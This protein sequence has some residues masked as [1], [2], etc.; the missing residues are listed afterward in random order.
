MY[1]SFVC[2]YVVPPG[3][4]YYNNLLCYDYFSSL[5]VVSCTFSALCMYS[6]FGHHP[7]LLG[8]LCAKFCFFHGLH[9]SDSPRRKIMYSITQSPSLYDAPGSE[10][11]GSEKLHITADSTV[12]ETINPFS[13]KLL[14][15]TGSSAILV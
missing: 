2:Q 4:C 14:L 15:F 5:S 6:K 13:S 1:V 7:H 8:Y 12:A 10:A 11:C 3:E 9:C